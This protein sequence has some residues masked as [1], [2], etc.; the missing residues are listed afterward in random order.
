MV[1]TPADYIGD[2]GGI[3]ACYT[4]EGYYTDSNGCCHGAFLTYVPWLGDYNRKPIV[5]IESPQ[6]NSTF[7]PGSNIT[8]HL[9]TLDLDG[10]VWRVDWSYQPVGGAKVYFAPSY[11]PPFSLFATNV[12]P[13]EY[14]VEAVGY[15]TA[16]QYTISNIVRVRVLPPPSGPSVL[17]S[18]AILYP[19]QSRTSPSGLYSMLYQGDGN[20][21][22]HGPYGAIIATGTTGPA[23][24][25]YMNPNGSLEV[26]NAYQ[27]LLWSSFTTSSA[28]AGSHARV[29][30]N[31]VVAIVRPDGTIVRQWP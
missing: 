23:G 21:V 17:L 2:I 28:N 4:S 27:Q 18:G 15:D 20:L 30:D 5:A 12:A 6:N 9:H 11:S 31:G 7:G 16:D 13:G 14:D 22:L 29:Q 8:F 3:D 26:Y 24:G 10:R 19:N 1:G 25:T